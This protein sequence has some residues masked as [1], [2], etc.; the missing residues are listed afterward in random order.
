MRTTVTIPRMSK[1]RKGDRHKKR[2]VTMRLDERLMLQVKTLAEKNRRTTTMEVTIA[3]EEYLTRAGF[4]PPAAPK[5][6]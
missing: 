4:W 3:L 5:T 2:T 1:K 6:E